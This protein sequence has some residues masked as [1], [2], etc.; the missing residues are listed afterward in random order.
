M[1]EF[2][3]K[4]VAWLKARKQ[5]QVRKEF[6]ES[7][8]RQ[9]GE[10]LKAWQIHP[11]WCD[12]EGYLIVGERRWRAAKLVGLEELDACVTDENLLPDDIDAIPGQENLLR[13]DLKPIEKLRL[14][15]VFLARNPTWQAKELAEHLKQDASTI[16]K[17]LSV[18]KCIPSVK[19]AF[20]SGAIGVTDCYA[21]SRASEQEQAEMLADKLGGATRDA[22]EGRVRRKRSANTPAVRTSRVRCP[23]TSGVT[24]MVSGASVSLEEFIEALGEARKQAKRALNEKL[25]VKTWQAVMADKA[26]A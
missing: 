18:E 12:T 25:D 10:S 8:L 16:C 1:R 15:Q 17:F 4:K 5:G 14:F 7:E 20:A 21:M 3:R 13:S 9:L 24:V 11:V 19:E 22:L 6:V 26:K 23:L 2:T